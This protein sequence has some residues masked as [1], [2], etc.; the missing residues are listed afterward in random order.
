MDHQKSVPLTDV[1]WLLD[2]DGSLCAHREEW[3][4]GH[5]EP[6]LLCQILDALAERS[7]GLD[8]NTG[9]SVESLGGQS[10][11]FLKHPGFFEHGSYYWNG[12]SKEVL[13]S[14]QMPAAVIAMARAWV[15]ER[16]DWVHLELKT[17]SLRLIPIHARDR[18]R[19]RSEFAASELN[20]ILQ[21]SPDLYGCE[22][23]RA[24]EIAL[25]GTNK[26]KAITTLL[27]KDPKFARAVPIVVGD[28]IGDAEVAGAVLAR[29]GFVFLVGSHCGWITKIS[30][31]ASQVAF[32]A[33]PQDLID[34][35][36]VIL[37]SGQIKTP[38][39]MKYAGFKNSLNG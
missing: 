19:L 7:S 30:H 23:W 2:Y 38:H 35:L 22:S 34:H 8:W 13:Q 9:R 29:G 17:H 31:R 27:A 32:F 21:K 6:K 14:Q 15:A 4:F 10:A 16:A 11:H 25:K 36:Q 5:Y 37:K 39:T 26:S 24:F 28:D 18:A 20:Q 33:T 3:E 1:Y 12:Q